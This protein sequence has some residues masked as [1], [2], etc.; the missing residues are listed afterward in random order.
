LQKTGTWLTLFGA[1]LTKGKRMSVLPVGQPRVTQQAASEAPKSNLLKNLFMVLAPLFAAGWLDYRN[2]NTPWKHPLIRPMT[3]LDIALQ[4]EE[5]AKSEVGGILTDLKQT[6]EVSNTN[7]LQ[8]DDTFAADCEDPGNCPLS[9]QPENLTQSVMWGWD[10]SNRPFVAAQYEMYLTADR[11]RACV[12]TLLQTPNG[13]SSMLAPSNCRS[14]NMRKETSPWMQKYLPHKPQ[15]DVPAQNEGSGGKARNDVQL[16]QD[17]SEK[18]IDACVKKLIAKQNPLN[19]DANQE[20]VSR[21]EC[22]S[23]VNQ[24]KNDNTK[25]GATTP[26]PNEPTRA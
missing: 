2:S 23:Q 25:K 10:S 7:F 16:D 6:G 12:L 11:T 1:N 5:F 9:F 21:E 17:D 14:G 4:N 13:T 3:A 20:Q 26:G 24:T 18:A 22:L 15:N 19:R 8:W